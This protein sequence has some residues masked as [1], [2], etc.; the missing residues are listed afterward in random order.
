MSSTGMEAKPRWFVLWAAFTAAP[1]I[2]GVVAMLVAP[3]L[4]AA[5]PLLPV[6]R[7]AFAGLALVQLVSGTFLMTRASRAVYGAPGPAAPPE[8]PAL[9]EPL[10][11][12]KAFIV[13]TAFVESCAIYGF[14]L[15]FLGAPVL[16]YLPFGAATVAVMI[17]VGLPTGLRYWGERESMSPGSGGAPPIG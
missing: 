3:T 2:Y 1:V 12:Q 13:A 7:L 14:V 4:P 6:L 9:A 10:A 17:A 5:S 11:F 16:E 8:G 15:V